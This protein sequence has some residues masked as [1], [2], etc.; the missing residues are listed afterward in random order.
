MIRNFLRFASKKYGYELNK[1]KNKLET[2]TNILFQLK[3]DLVLDIGANVGQYALDLRRNG[4]KGKIISFEPLPTAYKKLLDNSKN[5]K[6]WIIYRRIALGDKNKI[7]NIYHSKNSF[8]SSTK[9]ILKLHLKSDPSSFVINNYKVDVI[10]LDKIYLECKSKSKNVFVK[11]DTQGSE[12]E[13]LQGFKNYLQNIS[14]VKIELSIL[15][16]YKN[17]ITYEFFFKYLKKKNFSLWSIEPS[18][19]SPANGRHLQFDAIF[20]NNNRI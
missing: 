2:S 5:D 20:I 11:I 18:F 8:S 17:Q 4:Y 16:L 9:K 10:N 7:A 6:N 13:I 15:K 1:I 14:G 3:V 19:I 12:A